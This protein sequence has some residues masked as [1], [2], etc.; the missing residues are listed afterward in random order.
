MTKTIKRA[1]GMTPSLK[2]RWKKALEE[3]WSDLAFVV[4]H[5]PIP[6]DSLYRRFC[7]TCDKAKQAL[8]GGKE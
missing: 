3:T 5:V 4:N 7:K 1:A 6:N 2:R 8:G